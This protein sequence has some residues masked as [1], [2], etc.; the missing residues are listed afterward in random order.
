MLYKLLKVV[1][2]TELE[3]VSIG[4]W[5]Q[6]NASVIACI[7]KSLMFMPVTNEFMMGRDSVLKKKRTRKPASGAMLI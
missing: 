1:T 7:Y 3:T 5:K 2:E 6:F 4:D